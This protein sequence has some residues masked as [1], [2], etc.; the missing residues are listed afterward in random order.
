MK[1]CLK[2]GRQGTAKETA[3]S[4][5]A[6]LQGQ[7]EFLSP[8]RNSHRKPDVLVCAW[9]SSTEKADK[10]GPLGLPGQRVS[11]NWELQTNERSC[12]EVN[13]VPED[14]TQNCL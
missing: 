8:E 13:S 1:P 12:L 6:C 5:E 9:N 10:G 2:W 11:P 4:V 14:D 3:R 7:H